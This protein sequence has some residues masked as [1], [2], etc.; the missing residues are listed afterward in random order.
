MAKSPAP[1]E[2]RSN[3]S[4]TPGESSDAPSRRAP[5]PSGGERSARSKSGDAPGRNGSDDGEPAAQAG[6]DRPAAD[7]PSAARVNGANAGGAA[8]AT[9][10][11]YQGALKYLN[12][13]TDIERLRASR[14]TPEMFKLDRMQAL[15]AAMGNP[16][17]ALRFIHIAGTKGKGSTCEMTA[18]CLEACGC[19]V[20]AYTSPHILDVRERIRINRRLIPQ[21]DFAR[22][23]QKVADAAASLSPSL[24]EAT[25]FELTTAMAFQYFADEAVDIAVIEC[26]L[27]GRLDSTNVITPLVTA[28]TSISLDH[29]Q[30]LGSTVELIAREKAGIFKP[31]VPALT[32]QQPGE[33]IAV[34]REAAA[35]AGTQLHVL[36]ED[37]EFSLRHDAGTGTLRSGS[38]DGGGMGGGGR[39]G[40]RGGAV[41]GGGGAPIAGGS[42]P[43]TRI[44]FSTPRS[45]YEHVGVPLKGEHQAYN[46]GLA[47]AILDRL[48]ERGMDISEAKVIKGLEGVSLPGRMEMACQSPRILLDGAHNPESVKCLIKAIGSHIRYDSL[49]VIFGCAADKD[50]RG[51]L[52]QISLG[53]DKVIFTRASKNARAADPRELH[54]IFNELS[55]KMSQYAETFQEAVGLAARAVS[56]D[57]LI[58]VT[59][60]FY[61]LG[62]A[63][64][65][66]REAEN[67][68]SGGA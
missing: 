3:K 54:R 22:T 41:K 49:V 56:R 45:S 26:G 17:E 44:S 14:V 55:G 8:A 6:P 46:C 28:V 36:G 5:H 16:H 20:G 32:V 67:R 62:D 58:C 37:I 63:K 30:I 12:D 42:G 27:G 25:Y 18:T 47:L 21:G 48:A 7:A 50:V 15:L 34:L 59:G 66:L 51:M 29:T 57:D 64:R 60:S 9:P 13:R 1:S 4:S 65:H 23:A 10:M 24:G 52:Q 40:G 19:T 33:V 31:G 38:G 43:R 53:A 39:G 11:S 61:L 2:R 68:R 35:A